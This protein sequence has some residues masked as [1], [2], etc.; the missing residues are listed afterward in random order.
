[1]HS[2]G[3]LLTSE[4]F[5]HQN[6]CDELELKV[7]KITSQFFD[8]I[9][10][11]EYS[12]R[13]QQKKSQM[14]KKLDSLYSFSENQQKLLDQKAFQPYFLNNQTKLHFKQNISTPESAPLVSLMDVIAIYN[15]QS[16]NELNLYF[17]S[18][19]TCNI[20]QSEQPCSP[21]I[22]N[23]S[24]SHQSIDEAPNTTEYYEIA[25]QRIILI[26]NG[27]QSDYV[28]FVLKNISNII[29]QQ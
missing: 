13:D 3:N 23:S 2:A 1:M 10:K 17:R 27:K 8:N 29:N 21:S 12:P 5:M 9:P 6:C 19:R 4:S 11:N 7:L 22:S 14:I 18:D 15:N 20:D 26:K 24:F 16:L 28:Q 25:F